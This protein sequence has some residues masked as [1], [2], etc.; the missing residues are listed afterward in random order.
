MS[1]A[2]IPAPAYYIAE[3]ELHDADRL[4]PYTEQVGAT[5]AAHG[6]R[7]IV[8][9]GAHESLEGSAPQGRV[10]VIAFD[11]LEQAHAWHHSPEYQRIMPFRQS[12]G[13]TR[14]FIVEGLPTQG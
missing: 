12:A 11:S 4:K 10:V 9:G 13:T 8:M 14:S 3:F 7:V 1:T 6:G 5:I 2:S